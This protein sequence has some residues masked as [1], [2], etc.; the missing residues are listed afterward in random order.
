MIA[1]QGFTTAIMAILAVTLALWASPAM[2]NSKYAAVVINADTGEIL[3]DKYSTKKRYPASLTKMMT[4]YLLFEEVEAGRLTLQ[5]PMKVSAFAAGQ[6]PSKLGLKSGSTIT[7]ETAIQALIIDSSNDVAVVVA[8]KISGT[9]RKF[10]AKMTSK[11]RSMGMR[12]TRFRNASGLPDRRQITTA[13][14]MAILAKRVSQDF[15]QFYPYFSQ[16]S[17]TYNGRVHKTHNRVVAKLVGASGL[18]TGYTRASGYNLATVA[19]RKGNHLIGIVLGGRSTRTRD[20]HMISIMNETF[21]KIDRNPQMLAAFHR[22]KI[23][24][25]L[26]PTTLA[27]LGGVWPLEQAES[28]TLLAAKDIDEPQSIGDDPVLRQEIID[29]SFNLANADGLTTEDDIGVLLSAMSDAERLNYLSLKRAESESI[30]A[31]GDVDML[32]PE[33]VWSIQIGAYKSSTLA[34]TTLEDALTI[35]EPW[36]GNGQENITTVKR[37]GKTLYR[38][39]IS[40]LT[41]SQ[42]EAACSALL[43]AG[44]ECFIIRDSEP[45]GG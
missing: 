24:P 1:K 19:E 7:V 30:I 13:R 31:Q 27:S 18:K 23:V 33:L 26:K 42:A 2:A 16:K 40:Y 25:A 35:A 14:D 11:A 36:I 15:P 21:A 37:D 12:N 9:Q 8:E 20:A 5:T 17:F 38:T 4:L 44:R 41:D 43:Q 10:A 22:N 34:Q 6:P 32:A 28:S 39:R 3:F 29:A 45:L